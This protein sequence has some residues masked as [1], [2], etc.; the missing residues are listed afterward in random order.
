MLRALPLLL[1]LTAT[2][3]QCEGGIALR[4][5]KIEL[6]HGAIRMRSPYIGPP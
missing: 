2:P 1:L 4:P 3:V 5:Q 6:Q